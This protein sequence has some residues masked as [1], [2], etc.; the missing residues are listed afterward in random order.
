MGMCIYTLKGK[1][2]GKRY[3]AGIWCW[4][5]KI[6]AERDE[7]GCFW[8]CPNCEKRCSDNTLSYNPA[9]RELGF[10]KT[11]PHKKEGI[12]GASA[13][14]WCIDKEFGLGESI[15]KVKYKLKRYKKLKTE[16]GEIWTIKQVNN[17]FLDIIKEYAEIGD[18]E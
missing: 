15:E 6:E 18:F 16:Y 10:D 12:N 5:C 2:I 13:W 17:M 8:F 7:I 9:F 11:K 3:A 1:N 4:N 14:I